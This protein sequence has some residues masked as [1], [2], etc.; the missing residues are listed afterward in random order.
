MTSQ[1]T[2]TDL[3]YQS[4]GSAD[5]SA[6]LDQRC[7]S[8]RAI[9]LD[10]TSQTLR[11]VVNGTVVMTLDA[12]FGNADEPTREGLFFVFK[13]SRDQVSNIYG[14]PMPFSLFFSGGQ[15]IHY[16]SD[17]ATNGYNGASHG[18]VNVRNWDALAQLFDTVQLTD[19]VV[20]YRS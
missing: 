2:A 14:T 19:K 7:Q 10:K 13:K 15:A 16:S 1:P 18:C 8:G 6:P 9:C 11:W 3:G 5:T 4:V 17:F 12:R 20:V